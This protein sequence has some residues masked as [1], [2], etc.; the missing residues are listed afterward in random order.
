MRRLWIGLALCLVLLGLLGCSTG[1]V[2]QPVYFADLT[3]STLTLSTPVYTSVDIPVS[4][5]AAVSPRQPEWKPFPPPGSTTTA[6]LFAYTDNASLEQ[7]LFFTVQVPHGYVEGSNIAFYM[8]YAYVTNTVGQAAKFG[9]EYTWAN[10]NA[11]FNPPSTVYRVLTSTNN[12]A[13][14]HYWVGFPAISGVGKTLGSMLVCR[15]F[16]N[17]SSADD[18]YIGGG[19]V[20]LLGVD[21]TC[22]VN[23]LGSTSRTVK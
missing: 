8:H 1:D 19:Y 2:T 17:S 10:Q 11:L 9:L 6:P 12:D 16:R 20:A 3:A 7:E 13:S 21:M 22:E 18:T 5:M 15:V 14:Y 4:S 23:T